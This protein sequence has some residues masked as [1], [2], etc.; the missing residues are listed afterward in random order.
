MRIPDLCNVEVNL[1]IKGKLAYIL[2][3]Q[4]LPKK[5]EPSLLEMGTRSCLSD[6][7]ERFFTSCPWQD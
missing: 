6:E 5:P 2:K 4:S 7:A 3:A 1:T